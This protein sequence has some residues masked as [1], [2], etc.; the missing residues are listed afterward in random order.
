[1]E[2]ACNESY[3]NCDKYFLMD[4]VDLL[5]VICS[6][7]INI[8]MLHMEMKGHKSRVNSRFSKIYTRPVSFH[9]QNPNKKVYFNP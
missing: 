8:G 3:E 9:L 2:L 7:S 5:G 6:F 1:M 4:F